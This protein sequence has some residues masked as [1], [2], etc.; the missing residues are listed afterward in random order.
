MDSCLRS[1]FQVTTPSSGTPRIAISGAKSS[2]PTRLARRTRD[3]PPDVSTT[4][5]SS[6]RF[7]SLR[8]KQAS[9]LGF[10]N[11]AELSL[12][13]KMAP[14]V[15]EVERFLLELN[16]RVRARA[17]AELNE[18]KAAAARDGVTD[19]EPWDLA[20]YSDRVRV[21]RLGFSED[22][23]RP[24]FSAPRVLAGLFN[25]AKRQFGVR[26]EAVDDVETW[27]PL[28]ATYS[29][30]DAEGGVLGLFYLDLYARQNKRGGAW[31]DE[32]VGRR[33]TARGVQIPSAYLT[34]NFGSPVEGAPTLWTH[35]EVV[36]I[37][38]E[39]GHALQHLLT[40]VDEANAS[41]IRGVP[42]DAVELPS[43]FME[44]WCFEPE[45]LRTF[46]RHWQTDAPI[47]D[48]LLEGLRVSRAFHSG[49]STVRQLELALF[50]LRI[51]R[52]YRPGAGAR[53]AETLDAVRADVGVLLPP[54]FA[55][56][57]HSFG[58]VFAGGYAA[59]YYS[60]KWAEVLASDAFSA[61]EE[62]RFAPEIGGRFRDTI[63]ALG[64]S[65]DAMDVFVEFRGRK[66]TID[67]LL[68]HMGLESHLVTPDSPSGS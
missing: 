33:R 36:T 15:E 67:A 31:M 2:K 23:L 7:L 54:P 68:R 24:Y 32:C 63:L 53:I 22:D 5:R 29:V 20:Y 18:V 11:F 41:G 65:R 12:A 8:H 10:S 64:G 51:H 34:C 48:S 47:P 59:G 9:L 40:R 62:G 66:P 28:V 44:H 45:F 37:F 25:L 42:W 55:R 46:A 39:F 61:F 35:S 17:F 38:H 26:I 16:G 1:I 14:S 30:R 52:D 57:A 19:F 6:K 43:Q 3:R 27:H 56:T 58:H 21:E 50:D 60:Y 49:L 13:P 4:R